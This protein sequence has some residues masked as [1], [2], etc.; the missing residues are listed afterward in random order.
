MF[1]RSNR[2]SWSPSQKNRVAAIFLLPVW[3]LALPGRYFLPF[4]EPYRLRIADERL[5]MLPMRELGA[6]NLKLWTGN[7][8]QK[9]E[10][11]S[12][13]LETVRNV[14]RFT[15]IRKMRDK[16]VVLVKKPEVVVLWPTFDLNSLKLRNGRDRL[17]DVLEVE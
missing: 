10:V 9:P 5:E 1:L 6:T 12:K 3:P 13:M 4:S 17:S 14:V 11:H 8:I 16:K 7:R 2:K 15:V